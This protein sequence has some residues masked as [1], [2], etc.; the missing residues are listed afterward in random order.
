MSFV[1]V[2]E[3]KINVTIGFLSGYTS[4][5]FGD[6]VCVAAALSDA[7]SSGISREMNVR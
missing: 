2:T 7:N 1:V 3:S 5:F 4:S 6:N